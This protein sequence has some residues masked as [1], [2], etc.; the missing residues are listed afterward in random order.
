MAATITG[1]PQLIQDSATSSSAS[2]SVPAD[3]E[4]MVVMGQYWIAG[5]GALSSM[6]MDSNACTKVN[7]YEGSDTGNSFIWRYIVPSAMKGTSKTLAWTFASTIIE[8]LNAYVIFLKNVDTTGTGITGTAYA[9]AVGSGTS[10]TPA[11][12]ST[13]DDTCLCTVYSYSGVNPDAGLA[14]QT[15]IADSGLYNNCYNAVGQKAGVSGTTTMS[16]SGDYRVVMAISV[17]GTSGAVSTNTQV[18]IGD[19]WKTVDSIQINIGDVWKP[20]TK[21]QINIGDVWKD[22]F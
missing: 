19:V 15:E 12:N 6:T 9:K 22:V 20:V 10:V 11:F 4:Y 16:G 17:A 5:G 13:V 3:A 14:G 8:G 7:S 1:T 21:V 18:N 2:V